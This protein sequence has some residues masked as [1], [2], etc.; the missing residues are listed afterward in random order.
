MEDN[1]VW[2]TIIGYMLTPIAGVVSW[3]AAR[4]VRN[5]STLRELQGTIDMLVEKNK[6][7]YHTITELNAEVMSLRAENAELKQGQADMLTELCQLRDRL[8]IKP[9][10][11]KSNENNQ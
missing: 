5:N 4:R 8:G 3:F 11:Q 2:V 1:N 6:E 7:L 9:K 10:K